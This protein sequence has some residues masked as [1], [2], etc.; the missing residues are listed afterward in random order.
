ML[1][2]RR[3][4]PLKEDVVQMTTIRLEIEAEEPPMLRVLDVLCRDDVVRDMDLD[5]SGYVPVGLWQRA[6]TSSRSPVRNQSRWIAL[7]CRACLRGQRDDQ[8]VSPGRHADTGVA[9]ASSYSASRR[10]LMRDNTSRRSYQRCL[11]T[12]AKCTSARARK[13]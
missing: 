10:R 3:M 5:S 2:H 12:A 6:G 7:V 1:K 9:E 8:P 4:E 13:P 11:T